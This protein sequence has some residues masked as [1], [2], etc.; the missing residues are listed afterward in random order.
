MAIDSIASN[1][2]LAPI[3]ALLAGAITSFTPC[4]LTSVPL[5]IGYVGS[6]AQRDV[7]KAFWLSATFSAGMAVT[8]T[9]LGTAALTIGQ[10]HAGHWKLVVSG[11]WDADGLDGTPNL[12]DLQLHPVHVRYG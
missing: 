8:F 10:A 9:I 6:T 12:G 11:S 7:R 2:W 3:F 5:V 4:A 1:A